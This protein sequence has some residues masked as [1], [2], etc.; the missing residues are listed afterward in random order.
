MKV[1]WFLVAI[2]VVLFFVFKDGCKSPG[3][4]QAPIRTVGSRPVSGNF[5]ILR[6]FRPLKISAY[7][8]REKETD[9]TPRIA[10]SGAYVF[11][12]M[13]A[14]SFEKISPPLNSRGK[15][16]WD[17]WQAAQVVIPS[18]ARLRASYYKDLNR[19]PTH[20]DKILIE[21]M[22]RANAEFQKKVP[23]LVDRVF[24]VLDYMPDSTVKQRRSVDIF[25]ENLGEAY[26]I[27]ETEGVVVW[28]VD[29]PTLRYDV[30][31]VL[32]RR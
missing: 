8:A 1:F 25:R 3:P 14:S 16:I 27:G 9:S 13:A 12:G 24:E 6:K 23:H 29:A 15:P 17:G 28:L 21:G 5:R 11:E 7:T 22:V 10:S 32:K 18:V 26:Q 4:A 20:E 2:A 31:Y 19:L 30:R